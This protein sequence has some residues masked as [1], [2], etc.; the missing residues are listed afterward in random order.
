MRRTAF[1]A[2]V[3]FWTKAMVVRSRRRLRHPLRARRPRSARARDSIAPGSRIQARALL[4]LLAQHRYRL[5]ANDRVEGS[6]ARVA[7]CSV[8]S[9]RDE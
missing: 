1:N 6:D 5:V 8:F 9:S 3:A 4:F 7:E 2:G